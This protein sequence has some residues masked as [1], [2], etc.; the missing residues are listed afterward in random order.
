M[1]ALDL[2]ITPE[3]SAGRLAV[4]G[5]A[6]LRLDADSA[7]EVVLEL[8][9]RGPVSRFAAASVVG[10]RGGARL[11]L[12]VPEDTAVLLA[13]LPLG[14]VRRRGDTVEVS[15][16]TVTRGASSQLLVSRGLA[17]GSWV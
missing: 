14:R 15:F 8:N 3:P 2:D 7:S 1:V 4:S 17:L 5:R 9:T 12:R 10:D 16:R 13:R 6:R 11:N